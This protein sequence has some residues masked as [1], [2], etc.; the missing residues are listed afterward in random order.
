[1]KLLEQFGS[2]PAGWEADVDAEGGVY[3]IDHVHHTTQRK[4]P[5]RVTS[6]V[7][8]VETDSGR[9][10]GR[11]AHSPVSSDHGYQHSL[12]AEDAD[13]SRDS[14]MFSDDGYDELP[15]G[16]T[17][18]EAGDATY[19]AHSDTR[20]ISWCNPRLALRHG[21]DLT[22]LPDTIDLACDAA[23][24]Y[25]I[26]HATQRTTRDLAGLGVDL[27][28]LDETIVSDDVSICDSLEDV[29]ETLAGILT[30]DPSGP[31]TLPSR[32][33][34]PTP[35]ARR[36]WLPTMYKNL[37]AMFCPQRSDSEADLEDIA[38]P[39]VPTT[40]AHTAYP[41]PC[42]D[43]LLPAVATRRVSKEEAAALHGPKAT[44]CLSP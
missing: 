23:G 15:A 34:T 36:A 21:V 3:F 39:A 31:A 35:P 8:T 10:C 43:T 37:A 38:V 41:L 28:D 13:G 2:L 33:P 1:M 32:A 42:D 22:L 40:P 29:T 7:V 25:L 26:D 19:Y 20:R 4:P 6:H 11:D 44:I 5:P 14:D 18:H 9:A 27:A 24:L 16:W 17:R 30:V 12:G